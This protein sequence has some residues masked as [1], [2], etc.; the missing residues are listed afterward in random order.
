MKLSLILPQPKIGANMWN[1]IYSLNGNNYFS[2]STFW[3]IGDAAWGQSLNGAGIV[4][5]G[6]TPQQAQSIDQ[7]TDDGFPQTGMITAR[8]ENWG[9]FGPN[10]P[11]GVAWAGGNV[12]Q[13]TP[14]TS[15]T[16][17]STTTCYDNGG[18]AGAQQYST[19]SSNPNCA[20]SFQFQ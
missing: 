16:A 18:I 9:L 5:P 3:A 17:A 20:L 6:I 12:T 7:K 2:I 4:N 1:Y 10:A 15:A 11:S 19:K 14:D 8:Y 13:G